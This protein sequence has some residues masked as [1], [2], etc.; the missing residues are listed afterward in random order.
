MAVSSGSIAFDQLAISAANMGEWMKQNEDT[1][2][3]IRRVVTGISVAA[4]V[5]GAAL[6]GGAVPAQAYD[7]GTFRAWSHIE[8]YGWTDWN[9]TKSLGLR[10]EAVRIYQKTDKTLCARAHVATIGWQGWQCTSTSNRQIDIGTTGRG[11][12]IEAIQMYTPG[13]NLRLNAHIQNIGDVT[14]MSAGPGYIV[15]VG[16]T[17]RGLR[18]EE[19]SFSPYDW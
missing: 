12:A 2:G 8:S 1:R 9:G 15:Q 14:A 4:V 17:G 19:F 16:T 18:M 3:R 13:R 6:F 5:C 7:T 11:V 10:L